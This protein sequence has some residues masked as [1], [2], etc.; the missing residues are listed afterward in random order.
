MSGKAPRL[1]VIAGPNGAGKSTLVAS[2]LRRYLPIVNPDDIARD[3]P[4]DQGRLAIAG[5]A[6]LRERENLLNARQSFAIETTLSGAGA[7]RF[8][9]RCKAAGCRVMFIYVGLDNPGLSRMRV[10]DRVGK[11]GHDVPSVDLMRRYP[12]SLAN[13][14]PALELAER[15]WVLDNSGDRRR[16]LCSRDQ[17]R[18]R[19][20]AADLPAW[21]TRAIPQPLR[22]V[23]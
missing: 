18:T 20:L 23:E 2:R 15:A 10:L 14:G 11:G 16:L 6:A 12:D 5:R 3:L 21:A 8:M 17:D 9:A 1:W 22:I 4:N 7:L 13:V 19:F